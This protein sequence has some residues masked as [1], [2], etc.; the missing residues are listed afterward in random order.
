MAAAAPTCCPQM[1]MA[2]PMMAQPAYYSEPNCGNAEASCGA[3]FSGMGMV[4]YGPEMP[5]EYGSCCSD[6]CSGGGCTSGCC[7][8]GAVATPPA[9]EAFVEPRPA[10]E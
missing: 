9:P 5:V 3:P 8:G 10:A 2:Q 1:Q 6:G 7:D 4:S